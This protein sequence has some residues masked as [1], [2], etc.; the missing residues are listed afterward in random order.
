ML[1]MA[2]FH[3]DSINKQKKRISRFLNSNHYHYIYIVYPQA[4]QHFGSS[5]QSLFQSANACAIAGVCD[6]KLYTALCVQHFIHQ[7]TQICVKLFRCYFSLSVK[8]FQHFDFLLFSS[9]KSISPTKCAI[10]LSSHHHVAKL[11]WVKFWVWLGHV[12]IHWARDN[13]LNFRKWLLGWKAIY[14]SQ[15]G[16]HL[17]KGCR[18]PKTWPKQ[19]LIIHTFMSFHQQCS[20]PFGSGSIPY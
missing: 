4:A 14:C 7:E 15:K 11:Y 10:D 13:P 3:S 17:V 16:R 1:K 18:Y 2:A 8:V 19:L 5:R 12:M 6:M 20:I 9:I